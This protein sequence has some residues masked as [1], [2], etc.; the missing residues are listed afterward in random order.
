MFGDD[1]ANRTFGGIAVDSKGNLFLNIA[2]LTA[3]PALG[4][5]IVALKDSDGD[6]LPDTL[7]TFVGP[8]T[9]DSNPTTAA[10]IVALPG[11]GIAVYGISVFQNQSSQVIIYP[12]A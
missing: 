4:G 3:D 7:S 9:G 6:M 1:A 12:D 2:V 5:V 10:S 8:A 11:G